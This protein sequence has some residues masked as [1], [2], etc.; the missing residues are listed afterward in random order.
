MGKAVRS[1]TWRDIAQL[2]NH[3]LGRGSTL[4]PAHCPDWDAAFAQSVAHVIEYTV[5]PRFQAMDRLWCF[6]LRSDSSA[7]T[8]VT[9]K[10]P[11]TAGSNAFSIKNDRGLTEPLCVVQ[12]LASQSS[13]ETQIDY[14]ITVD[15]DDVFIESVSCVEI[16]RADLDEYSDLD[17]GVSI[18]RINPRQPISSSALDGIANTLDDESL[19][20]ARGSLLQW[21]VPHLSGGAQTVRFA[22]STT[23]TTFVDMFD[24]G[25][26]ALARK[27]GRSDTTGS[28]RVKMHGWLSA[29]GTGTVRVNRTSGGASAEAVIVST[30]EAWTAKIDFTIDCED[31][32]S[33]DGRQTSGSPAWDEIMP[34]FKVSSGQTLYIVGISCWEI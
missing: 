14:E 25:F 16:P 19:I 29:P 32:A 26:P 30:T 8:N 10:I 24:L 7:G 34:Q 2:Q 22:L 21:A 3:V 27:I 1:A 18:T 28:L 9:L 4:V 33:T 11:S 15:Q 5:L 20:G 6:T 13:A 12:E 17:R 23:S 31:L